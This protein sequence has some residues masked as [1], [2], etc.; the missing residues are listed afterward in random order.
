MIRLNNTRL[1]F[2]DF[3][4]MFRFYRDELGFKPTFG[5]EQDVYADF[6]A[7]G[8][9]V[10]LFRRDLMAQAV[11]TQELPAETESQDR[12]AL[13]FEA[14]NVD[15]EYTRM[16]RQGVAFVTPPTD[17]PDWGIRTAHLRD[18]D[19]NLL[20]VFSPISAQRD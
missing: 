4:A 19:G 6:D 15:A 18:P 14:E 10:A 2:A 1:L 3:P 7:G 17:M 13:I 16:C 9:N 11:G 8:A 12:V 20:E 5:S